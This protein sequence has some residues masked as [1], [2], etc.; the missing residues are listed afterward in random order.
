MG[1]RGGGRG[2]MSSPPA[3]VQRGEKT[4]QEAKSESFPRNGWGYSSFPVK[5]VLYS[6]W[7]SQLKK[8]NFDFKEAVK[9][10]EALHKKDVNELV[11]PDSK[12]AYDIPWQYFSPSPA[13]QVYEWRAL[14]LF[15]P[16]HTSWLFNRA[17]TMEL[18]G[19]N[20]RLG[21]R[22]DHSGSQSSFV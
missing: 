7:V 20:R 21:S 19:T 6:L 3:D 10:H 1:R 11:L 16:T 17:P 15:T 18:A 14:K 9:G 4:E 8:R 22:I 12:L 5:N 13:Y 2:W